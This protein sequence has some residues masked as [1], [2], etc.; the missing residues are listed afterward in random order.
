MTNVDL[1]YD[2][3]ACNSLNVIYSLLS[4]LLIFAKLQKK[5]TMNQWKINVTNINIINIFYIYQS[6]YTEI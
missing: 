6:E 2:L 3:T 5:A 1:N 4:V